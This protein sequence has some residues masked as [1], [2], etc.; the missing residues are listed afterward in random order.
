VGNPV[1]EPITVK[2]LSSR[3][4]CLLA[5]GLV[6]FATP[7]AAQ[8]RI[9]IL[10]ATGVSVLDTS[11]G[12]VRARFPLQ[13]EPE[14]AP[15]AI[16][17]SADGARLFVTTSIPATAEFAPEPVFLHVLDASTGDRLARI[18]TPRA[19]G[20]AVV[21]PDGSRAFLTSRRFPNDV[22][23]PFFSTAITIVDLA[24]GT[25]QMFTPPVMDA[26]SRGSSMVIHPG[27]GALY[28]RC[29]SVVNGTTVLQ[30]ATTLAFRV[31]PTGLEPDGG[32]GSFV[33]TGLEPVELSV[34]PDGTRL[35]STWTVGLAPN[36]TVRVHDTATHALLGSYAAAV[37][38]HAG[39]GIGALTSQ[40]ASRAFVQMTTDEF[41]P[42]F[43]QNVNISHFVNYIVLF[44]TNTGAT[45][46]STTTSATLVTDRTG[47]MTFAL[48]RT[49][50]S[51]L[52]ND[53]AA[54]TTI[55]TGSGGWLAAD[56]LPDP[57]P[58]DAA[59]SPAIFTTTGGN[60]TL[61]ITAAPSCTWSIDA[62][63]IPGVTVTTSSGTGSA[64]VPFTLGSAAAARRGLVRIGAR[65][66]AIEQVRPLMDIDEPLT[67]V[68]QQPFIVRGWA[69]ELSA[70]ASTASPAPATVAL[71]HVWAWP[72]DGSA[73]HFIGVTDASRPR[74]DIAAVF[75][76]AYGGAG[77][78]V[79]LQGLPTG[80]YA[81]VVYAQS[82]R[83]G[84][85]T[86]EK[87]VLVTVQPGTRVAIDA[88]V[89]SVPRTFAVSGW[90]ADVSATTGPGVDAVHVWAYP[91][92]GGAAIW[93]GAAS[94]G[95]MRDDIA[96]LYGDSFG[97]SG[98]W[99]F[100]SLPPGSYTLVVFARSTVTGEFNAATAPLTVLP[101]S[102][103]EMNLDE[104][105]ASASITGPFQ[106]QGWAIDRGAESGSGV[107]AFHIWAFPIAGGD[108]RFVGVGA[109]VARPDIEGLFGPQFTNAG[110]LLTS[111]TLPPGTYDLAVFAH[112]SVTQSFNN[113]RVVRIT[114]P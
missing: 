42:P 2:T 93:V 36:P 35:H 68:A 14:E 70:N 75:G 100:A 10:D 18:S 9:A 59:A 89:T 45:L 23:D 37:P 40:S 8:S 78:S 58:T 105:G 103:P 95:G 53:T 19:Y 4:V 50:L 97:R 86:Q 102:V 38:G 16:A 56:V 15:S 33:S 106:I 85:F 82:A 77:F 109:P 32:F 83:L 27:G 30:P 55:A 63:A 80:T 11:T 92:T 71:V 84:T 7:A 113:W 61:T 29:S 57:C 110:F 28:L 88:P 51:R 67:A 112:S 6:V 24:A 91:S 94:Y 62:S 90:A 101:G 22:G 52:D 20:R 74:P 66:V 12:E 48:E 26:C 114:V 104:P 64:T 17:S 108:P 43:G 47:A 99:L 73:P 5:A 65:S 25:S 69:I 46:G 111:A 54:P 34:S 96:K 21:T 81:I 79:P 41:G 1:E 76:S 60:G 107:D 72:V 13:L 39:F 87:G 31:T 44:D 49:R 98:Y 3:L